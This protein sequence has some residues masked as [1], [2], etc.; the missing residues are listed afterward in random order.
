MA[1]KISAVM[2]DKVAASKND[3]FESVLKEIK[4]LNLKG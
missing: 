2:A 1:V 3:A 4:R